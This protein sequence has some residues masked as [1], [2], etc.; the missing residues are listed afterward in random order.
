[1][2]AG[3]GG[4][5]RGGGARSAAPRACRARGSVGRS[6]RKP[7]GEP[8]GVHGGQRRRRA[9]ARPPWPSHPSSAS[10]RPCLALSGA[11]TVSRLAGFG[12]G[13][14]S[15]LPPT[16]RR[17]ILKPPWR[18]RSGRSCCPTFLAFDVISLLGRSLL[19]ARPTTSA[20]RFQCRVRADDDHVADIQDSRCS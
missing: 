7:P 5:G 17:V 18:F 11:N 15:S 4:G 9:G 19:R 1:M 8:L 14:R 10:E 13:G 3:P 12:W 2:E 20:E 16:P 6:E